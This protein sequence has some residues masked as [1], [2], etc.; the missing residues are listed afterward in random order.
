MYP[1]LTYLKVHTIKNRQGQ[2]PDVQKICKYILN[3][4]A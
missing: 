4:P 2:G 3:S 1:D